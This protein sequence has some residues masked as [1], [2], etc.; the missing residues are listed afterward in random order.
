LP[1]V[2]DVGVAER[3]LGLGKAFKLPWQFVLAPEGDVGIGTKLTRIGDG[4]DDSRILWG[5]LPG[6]RFFFPVERLKPAAIVLAEHSSAEF[7]R[8]GRG[9]PVLAMHNVGAGR[10]VF[11]AFDESYRWRSLY[12]QAYNRFWVNGIRYLFEGRAQA[13]NARL[14]LLASEEKVDLGDAIEITAEAKDEALQPLI[15][16]SLAVVVEREGEPAETLQLAAVEGVPG[17]YSIRLRPTT[18]GSY[19]V[20]AVDKV[21]KNAELTFQ[22]VAAI[23]ERHGPMDRAE[24]AAIAGTSGGELFD[25]P[26]ALLAALDRIPSRSATDVFRTPHAVWDGWPTVIFVLVVLSLEWLLRKRFNLL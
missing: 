5:R 24:L 16:D 6:Q 10:V 17:S 22:V 21:G 23:I 18:L 2:P 19:R 3:G 20:R 4:R 11:S 14:R 9:M 8:G 25:T 26:Q 7:R 13:G 15:A 1:V 12:E